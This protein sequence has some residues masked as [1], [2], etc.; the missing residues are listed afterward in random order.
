MSERTIFQLQ[1][2]GTGV[3]DG[4]FHSRAVK[5]KGRVKTFKNGTLKFGNGGLVSIPRLD[6]YDALDEFTIQATVL[7]TD[8]NSRQNIIEGQ[9]PPV[10]LFVDR[11]G[12]LVGSVH[13]AQGWKSVTSGSTTLPKNRSTPVS[14]SRDKAGM[15]R[16]EIKGQ[17][18][19]S[20]RVRE[21]LAPVGSNGFL[22]GAGMDGR[23]FQLKGQI[24][25][26][27]INSVA[28]APAL[29]ATRNRKAQRLQN[30]LKAQ[31]GLLNVHVIAERDE[32]YAR[33]QPIKSILS[34]VG[35]G[36]LNDL[37][38]LKMP[39][40]TVMSPGKVVVAPLKS[41]TVT[42]VDWSAIAGKL[43]VGTA[44]SK[45]TLIAKHV[46]N[47]NSQKTLKRAIR[48]NPPA[49]GADGGGRVVPTTI[50]GRPL[51]FNNL[52]PITPG[53]R[54]EETI[55]ADLS[56][57]N[58]NRFLTRHSAV[59][60][61]KSTPLSG[62]INLKADNLV[63]TDP[64]LVKQLN[65][66]SPVDWPQT[67][68]REMYFLSTF[69]LPIDTSVIVAN[70]L[71][72][73]DIELR[74]EPEVAKLYIIAEEIQV[75]ENSLINWQRPG[76][77]TPARADNPD[78]NG[79]GYSGQHLK[80]N[81]YDGID[82]EDGQGGSAGTAGAAG[83]SAP[84]LEIWTRSMNG[85]P[86]LDLNGEDG[87]QG[88]RGQRG[89]RGGNGA[90][91]RVGKRFWF[92]GWH[93]SKDPGDGGDGGNGGDG[94]RGGRGGSGADGGNITVGVLDG[95]LE[96]TV[97]TNLFRVKNQ[98]GQKGRG[99]EGGQG[100]SGGSG[101]QSGAG[102]TCKDAE[103]GHPGSRGQRGRTGDDGAS[104]GGDGHLNFHEFTE[105]AWEELLLRPWVTEVTPEY[106][107]PN[108]TLT[109]TG[110]AFTSTDRVHI[111]SHNL[112]PA[113]NPD[114]SIM[115]TIPG[116]I[117]GGEKSV[118]VR[119]PDGTES[120]RLRLW[121]K[122]QLDLITTTVFTPA[123]TV[124]LVG[125]AFLSG[126][127]V[128]IDGESVPATVA[129]RTSLSFEVPGTGGAGSSEHS[130]QVQ[131]RNPDGMLSNIRTATIP[132]I[133]EVP[134]RF[135]EHALNFDNFKD[136]APSWGTYEDTYGAAEIYHELLD[137]IFGHPILTAAFYAFYHHFLKGEDN[138][139]LATGFCTSM[140]ARVLDEF[141]T[142][143]TDTFTRVNLTASTRAELTGIHGRLLS[144]ESLL[145][146]HDQGRQGVG[147]VLTTYREIE[148]IFRNGCDRHN[149][150]MLFFIP[151]GEVWDDGYFD[152][153]S[154]S[155]CIVP[156][157]FLY[158][159]GHPG[160]AADGTTDPDGVTLRCW[161]CNHSPTDDTTAI[162]SQNCRL[163][164]R[165][166]G[167]VIHYDYFD[168]GSGV[169]FRS[170]DGITL[171][172]MTNGAYLLS[173]HDLP[174]SGPFGLTTFVLDF[175]LSPADLQVTDENGLRTGSFDGQI[176]S[177]IPDSH[178]AYLM[179]GMYLL[180]AD[181]AMD[182][183]IVGNGTGEYAYHSISPSGTSVSLEN[184]A[185]I[186]GEVDRLSMNGDGTQ[187]RITPGSA[188]SF[189]LQ[190][191]REVGGEIRA[192]SVTGA[193]GGP[194]EEVDVTLSPDLS[195]VRVGNRSAARTVDVRA[196]VVDATTEANAT[197]NRGNVALP[198]N[199]D[200]L[201]TVQNWD[202]LDLDVQ[203][204]SF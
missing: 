109:L 181:A 202:D 174:F 123:T 6:R 166:T 191:A 164:F 107:F 161:D 190:V 76:G 149:A 88:S 5:V 105:D 54:I 70:T 148:Q 56:R 42:T 173:D 23:S 157:Q 51:T 187:I 165:R 64:N 201:L 196:F 146:L 185:T 2:D 89:G 169:K 82:G 180:P 142:G 40:K 11:G 145:H 136:G 20:K 86:N 39:N 32:S 27:T 179:K 134:F 97:T 38:T 139:G 199:H 127:S 128:T 77:S 96:T 131:V 46:P 177:Q 197:S 73:R 22:L 198:Q 7:V 119:R 62:V 115:V 101:G 4:T 79:R 144:R 171:G 25:S 189:S 122:P 154:D 66:P 132:Q 172:M 155:H 194:L 80:P 104:L 49:L 143:S 24:K 118:F 138:G 152:S 3:F 162:E 67:G 41:E 204:I 18:V 69:V 108:D 135:P 113:V 99:G 14:F 43:R 163:V 117:T 158:P 13:T 47:R 33:L 130:I 151:A 193:G 21:D 186:P 34:A 9:T 175:L 37:A 44:T 200:L 159:E 63:V 106:V 87:I 45:K 120:N 53:L 48:Q 182:R 59:L 93:C 72:L 17:S 141:W 83:R 111:G 121:V 192:I 1:A 65:S 168:G 170:E 137:P 129:S 31:L 114:G 203:T 153:L 167:G 178:P 8:T 98:G 133:L 57:V 140:S 156:I 12:K 195:V 26:L 28:L 61:K 16:L 81:S 112:V 90:D 184:V 85:M 78:L 92:F 68:D 52:T 110:S 50:T 36:N 15:M 102:E 94:G 10:A 125:R 75:N 100:G 103:N 116:T 29:L 183:E 176:F 188:K 74:V 84:A 58:M 35:V 30:N 126:A 91:G 95:S 19:G 150:P 160:P 55:R 147:R 124:S 71:D 60:K